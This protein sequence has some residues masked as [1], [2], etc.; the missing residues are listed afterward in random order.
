MELYLCSLCMSSWHA[1]GKVTFAMPHYHH[2]TRISLSWLWLP[3]TWV[4]VQSKFSYL[5]VV[6]TRS[7]V[8][9][10]TIKCLYIW[11]FMICVVLTFLPYGR[12]QTTDCSK[13]N[14]SPILWS[15]DI[16]AVYPSKIARKAVVY[17]C[18]TV[19][20]YYETRHGPVVWW[21]DS[22]MHLH[23]PHLHVSM[24]TSPVVAHTTQA[25]I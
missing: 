16:R 14:E 22:F 15:P 17:E 9:N 4:R 25:L 13:S 18:E 7:L 6:C 8:E 2:N 5:I 23:K 1:Q 20:H 21:N 3:Y 12:P 24:E 10:R 19:N 11:H